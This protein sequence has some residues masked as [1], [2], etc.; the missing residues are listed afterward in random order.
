MQLKLCFGF[1]S[2]SDGKL[3]SVASPLGML[4]FASRFNSVD[5]KD[6]LIGNQREIS[7][8][9]SLFFG[10]PFED[11]EFALKSFK[12]AYEL[13]SIWFANRTA[14]LPISKSSKVM[15]TDEEIARVVDNII[16]TTVS[17]L[18]TEELN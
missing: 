2:L 16:R 5:Q 13:C 1:S 3:A 12:A 8:R 7:F 15:F 6:L 11:A 4:L 10:Y 17:L 18:E 14:N 9:N